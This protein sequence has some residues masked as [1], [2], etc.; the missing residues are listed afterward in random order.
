MRGH[1]KEWVGERAANE[2]VNNRG[3]GRPYLDTC[4]AASAMVPSIS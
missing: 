2:H 3:P 1:G 4:N